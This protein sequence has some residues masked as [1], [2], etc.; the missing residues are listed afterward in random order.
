MWDIFGMS[1]L[2]DEDHGIDGDKTQRAHDLLLVSDQG[3]GLSV[4]RCTLPF[5]LK[6]MHSS[7]LSPK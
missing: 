3:W 4:C 7:V 2:T 1:S 6:C 5:T